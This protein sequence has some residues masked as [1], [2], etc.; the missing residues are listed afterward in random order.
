MCR[1]LGITASEPTEFRIV[2][3]EAPRS[4]AALSRDHRDGW[5]IAV[6]EAQDGSWRIDKGVACAGEDER[7]HQLAIGSRGEL[8]ISHIRQKTVGETTLANTHPFRQGRW[9]F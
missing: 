8:L 6:Y 4:L 2:L 7:F 9:V 1:L 3:R 5:G